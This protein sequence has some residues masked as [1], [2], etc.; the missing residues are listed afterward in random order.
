VRAAPSDERLAQLRDGLRP[1]L[2]E[3]LPRQRWFAGD[4]AVEEVT[5]RSLDV[6][7]EDPLLLW[8]VLDVGLVERPDHT[9]QADPQADALDHMATYQL[10][11][12]GR[13]ADVDEKFLRGK[14]RV[15]LG[16]LDGLML[17]DALVDPM[18]ALDVLAVVAPDE[19]AEVARPLVVEQSNS[20]V[21]YDERLILKLFRRLHPEPN[22]DVEITRVL[23]DRGFPHVV[24]Q[25]AEL[26]R[27]GVDLAVV[28]DYLLG[29]TDGWQLAHTS[30]RDL[31]GSRLPPEETGGDFA[32]D[33]ETLGA[34]TAAL[35]VELAAA[36]GTHPAEPTAWRDTM[37]AQAARMPGAGLDRDAITAALDHA[38]KPFV[39]VTL[40]DASGGGNDQP[41]G[42][43]SPQNDS[44]DAV[45]GSAIRIHGD[46]HLGQFLRSDSGW[47]VLDF[48]GE[49]ARPVSERMV[50]SSPLQD[51]AGMMRSFHYAARTGLAER[52]RDVDA[53]LVKLTEAWEERLREAFWRGY[54]SVP[55]VAPLLP[56]DDARRQRLV[57]A[58][59]LDK[60]VYEVIYESKH[61]PSW[62]DIP[63]SAIQRMLPPKV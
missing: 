47:F 23:G 60:A 10:L 50:R 43:I 56:A 32:A 29:A 7:R 16:V 51:A 17:Y 11:V 5:I 46:L 57:R 28:R 22:P 45:V 39:G 8:L 34:V 27:D 41:S 1:M 6:C 38:L 18:L 61:R 33:A 21:V 14:E 13:P 63:A 15:T 55:E 44:V 26:R 4:R 52:G 53:E 9:D 25:R 49:P 40:S 12:A 36:F 30:L 59:E 31:L 24:T 35:H 62:V 2:A 48:E 20:S 19:R 37:R 58:F 54:Q 3:F 42:H